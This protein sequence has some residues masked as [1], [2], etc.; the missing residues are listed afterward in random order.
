MSGISTLTEC[1]PPRREIGERD[2]GI[3][4]PVVNGESELQA[5]GGS[6]V[7]GAQLPQASMNE[8]N[9]PEGKEED[10]DWSVPRNGELGTIQ[11]NPASRN[12][13]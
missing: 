7:D 3:H 1:E 13:I 8:Y 4:G 2:V 6:I 10:A 12:T 5:G 9:L 11:V